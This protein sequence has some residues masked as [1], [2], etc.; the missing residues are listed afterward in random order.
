MSQR[1]CLK[2]KQFTNEAKVY[3]SELL[4]QQGTQDNWTWTEKTQKSAI[5]GEGKAHRFT[6]VLHTKNLAASP[7]WQ[8]YMPKISAD[9][10]A[11]F[12]EYIALLLS[13]T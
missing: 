1:K 10:A 13:D 6:S 2:T 7:E 5:F 11:S 8:S 12:N 3:I 4:P 9:G